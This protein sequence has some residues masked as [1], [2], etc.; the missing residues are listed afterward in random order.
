MNADVL[1]KDGFNHTAL[2]D[3]AT[4]STPNRIDTW[5]NSSEMTRQ[6]LETKVGMKVTLVAK[7][8]EAIN[9]DSAPTKVENVIVEFVVQNSNW[10]KASTSSSAKTKMQSTMKSQSA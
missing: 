5:F 2:E 1:M 8:I 3:A 6:P 9:V 7:L 10:M 4:T